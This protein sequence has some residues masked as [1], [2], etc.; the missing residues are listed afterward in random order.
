MEIKH[1]TALIQQRLPDAKVTLNTDGRHYKA[2]I[3]SSLFEG[4][5]RIQQHQMVY[6][7]LEG[8]IG[9]TIHALS[10]QTTIPPKTPYDP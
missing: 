1:I 5:S 9:Q 3:E 2:Y 6:Q 7:A 10:L 8:H 4:K